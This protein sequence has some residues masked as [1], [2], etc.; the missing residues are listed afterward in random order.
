[1]NRRIAVSLLAVHMYDI[2][3]FDTSRAA[4]RSTGAA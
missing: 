4:G 1:M 3:G 2:D